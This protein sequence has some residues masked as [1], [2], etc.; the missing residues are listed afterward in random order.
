MSNN[1]PNWTQD[2]RGQW[3]WTPTEEFRLGCGREANRPVDPQ[4]QMGGY[5][6]VFDANGNRRDDRVRLG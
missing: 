3:H 5:F 6:C 2:S 4:R 1:N